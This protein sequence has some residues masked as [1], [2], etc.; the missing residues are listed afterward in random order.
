M[1]NVAGLLLVLAAVAQEA[2]PLRVAW[3]YPETG[4]PQRAA[5]PGDRRLTTALFEGLT[6]FAADGVTPEPGMAA[7]WK[8]GEDRK[9]WTF[10][11][12]EATWSDGSPVTAG[13][14]VRAWRRAIRPGTACPYRPLFRLFE[15]AQEWMDGAE[16]DALLV[17]FDD[18]TEAR[19]GELAEVLEKIA[20]HRHEAALRLR[21]LEA[22]A[23]AAAKRPDVQVEAVGFR[24]VDARTLEVRLV[25][26]VPDLPGLV[27]GMSFAPV[28]P[29]AE[30]KGDADWTRWPI[31]G[32]YLLGKV[33][34][35]GMTL[36][37]NPG[38]WDEAA[39]DRPE[40][41]EVSLAGNAA[42]DFADGRRDWVSGER[43]APGEGTVRHDTWGTYFLRLNVRKPPF[44]AVAVRMAVARAIDRK[45]VAGG[46]TPV[47]RLVPAAFPGYP[48]VKGQAFDPAVAMQG[49]LEASGF[50]TSTFPK[51]EIITP[52][53]DGLPEAAR[54]VRA[55]LEKHLGIEVRVRTLK[56]PAYFAEVTAGRFEA[57]MG[58]WMGGRFDPSAFLE[59]WTTG[60]PDNSG[61]WSGGKFDALLEKAEGT[62]GGEGRLALL[63]EAEGLLL[64][65]VPLIPL[66]AAGS[67][68]LV[69]DRLTGI[70]PNLMDRFPLKHLR[71]RQP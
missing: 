7:S 10:R 46:A 25:R 58:A 53:I 3:D 51:V 15:G 20:R 28:P 68:F 43:L 71:L 57:A 31:N 32:P 50:D 14:F 1:L 59:A 49:M 62:P 37:R 54:A 39:K 56:P 13:D 61:G 41:I 48:E 60:H 38:Y 23:E 65:E 34:P 35:A 16:A 27:G 9:T 22:A 64:G 33:T 8:E 24:A 2:G 66:Y 11:L 47:G 12:R 63:A 67:A 44:D 55:E 42:K 4:D 36:E 26:P 45:A 21:G 29:A 18:Q 19:R 30:G 6:T 17:V 5:L 40:R 70:T 52:D 69:S